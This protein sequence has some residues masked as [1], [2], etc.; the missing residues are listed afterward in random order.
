M[1]EMQTITELTNAGWQKVIREEE[2]VLHNMS[3]STDTCQTAFSQKEASQYFCTS[4]I[5]GTN[6]HI[7]K[8][9]LSVS[10]C[11]S[12]K[13]LMFTTCVLLTSFT[14]LLSPSRGLHCNKRGQNSCMLSGGSGWWES[15]HMPWRHTLLWK[16]QRA[17]M[18]G[19]ISFSNQTRSAHIAAFVSRLVLRLFDVHMFHP[20]SGRRILPETI[21][22]RW[23]T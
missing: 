8:T 16:W 12:K 21:G 1:S 23:A 11:Y 15:K 9:Y 5:Q 18:A 10:M 13:R 4:W 2:C 7:S 3:E 19:L 22:E 20:F 14:P 6:C 17:L